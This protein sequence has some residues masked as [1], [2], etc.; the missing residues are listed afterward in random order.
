MASGLRS[1]RALGVTEAPGSVVSGQWSVVSGKGSGGGSSG[2]AVHESKA[3]E[4]QSL[5]YLER[6]RQP[7]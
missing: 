4:L 6:L 1:P 3:L 5:R 2:V 7:P